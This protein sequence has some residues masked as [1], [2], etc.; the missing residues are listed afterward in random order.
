MSSNSSLDRMLA[1]LAAFDD[2]RLSLD[3]AEVEAITGASRAT[4]YRYLQ[5]LTRSGLL[6]SSVDGRFVIGSRPMELA[7]LKAENDPLVAAARH[8]IRFHA[9]ELGVSV[10]LCSF[11]G[12]R[13]LC[14]ESVWQGDT[15]QVYR[16]GHAV[17]MFRGAMGKVILA[18]L[19]SAQLRSIY[20]MNAPAIANAGLGDTV[21]AFVATMR[22]IR[23]AGVL[24]SCGEV[25]SDLVGIAAPI[26]PAGGSVMGSIVYALPRRQFEAT[27]PAMLKSRLQQLAADIE[28]DLV[29]RGFNATATMKMPRSPVFT[30]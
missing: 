11:F 21:E 3:V 6:T 1:I 12:D 27:D 16:S 5:A 29:Q 8:K 28:T 23:A 17:P 9:A 13:V 30:A 26:V 10:M 19:P 14:V 2:Q 20:R 18:R 4:A 25:V 7:R 24:T 22:N 15:P